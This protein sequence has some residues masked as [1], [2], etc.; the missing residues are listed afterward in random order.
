MPREALAPSSRNKAMEA[1]GCQMYYH[2]KF[3]L[4]SK[5]RLCT[6][7]GGKQSPPDADIFN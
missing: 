7:N 5:T 4:F 2:R 3:G 1:G 6:A